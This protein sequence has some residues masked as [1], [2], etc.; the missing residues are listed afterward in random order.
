MYKYIHQECGGIAFLSV[1]KYTSGD[2]VFSRDISFPD[3]SKPKNGDLALCFS[4]GKNFHFNTNNIML[5]QS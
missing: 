5:D 1:K 2:L 4:C 3:G